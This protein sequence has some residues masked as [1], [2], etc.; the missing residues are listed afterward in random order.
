MNFV[1]SRS[2]SI[3]KFMILYALYANRFTFKD[4][5]QSNVLIMPASTQFF[6]GNPTNQ[7]YWT[8]T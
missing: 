3:P 6:A 7:K 4:D 1:C 8:V 5:W 2:F